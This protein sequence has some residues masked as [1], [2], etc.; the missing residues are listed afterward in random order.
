[1]WIT[2]TYDPAKSGINTDAPKEYL[3]EDEVGAELGYGFPCHRLAMNAMKKGRGITMYVTPQN[4]TGTAA[5]GTMTVTATTALVGTIHMYI[6]DD[7]VPVAVAASASVTDIAS[8]IAAAVT[9]DVNLP[10]TAANVAGV[11][12]FTSKAK[13][14]Y[15]NFITLELNL[16]VNQALPGGVSIATVAMASGATDPDIQAALNGIGTGDAT[17]NIDTTESCH[18]Y[19]PTSALM[20]KISAYNGPGDQAIGGWSPV[21]G[22]PLRFLNA[23]VDKTY[24]QM[25]TIADGDLFDRT[26]AY[27][28]APTT[29]R[30]PAELA[31]EMM[32]NVAAI[33]QATPHASYV[34]VPLEGHVK[35]GWTDEGTARE[36]A[37]QNGIS[38][39]RVVNGVL[40]MDGMVTMYRPATIPVNNNAY[41]SFRNISVLQNAL[42]YHRDIWAARP[43]FT[44]VEDVSTVNPAEKAHVLDV[45]GVKDINGTFLD[46]MRGKAW[47]YESAQAIANQTVTLREANNGFDSVLP[48]VLSGEGVVNTALIYVDISLAVFTQ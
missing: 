46:G 16:G 35:P 20:G 17:N 39:T 38:C 26:D 10:V 31:A 43:S 19:E 32:G 4:E 40:T 29:Y 5:T 45:D 36:A 9:A 7:Y 27:I 13:G 41:R 15:G 6:A 25:K 2:A 44:I 23:V 3:S 22:K 1:M 24:S 28:A 47:I 42:K 21:V 11:V 12:T 14:T 18:G 48:I 33:N 8:A 30:H 37:I 34:A